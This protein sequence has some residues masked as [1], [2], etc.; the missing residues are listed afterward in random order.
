MSSPP[1]TQ[2]FSACLRIVLRE[3]SRPIGCSRKGRKQAS[4]CLPKGMSLQTST[5][6]AIH[7]SLWSKQTARGA[8]ANCSGCHRPAAGHDHLAERQLEFIPLWE[9]LAFL[10]CRMRRVNCP[11]R[12]LVVEEVPWANGVEELHYAKGRERLRPVYQVDASLT[13]LLWVGKQRTVGT[14]E[15]F[16]TMIW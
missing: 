1:R 12:G 4:I 5:G 15:G 11:T 8:A 14:F 13:R 2:R 7:R 3:R 6:A 9:F 10:L 16:F